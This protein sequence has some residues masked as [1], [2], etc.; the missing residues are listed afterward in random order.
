MILTQCPACAAPLPDLTA[1]QCSR[2]KTRYCGRTCQEYHWKAGHDKV[3][4]KIRKSGGAEQYHANK[5]YTEAVTVAAKACAEDTKGQ[6]CYICTEAVHRHTGEGLVRGCGCHTT[7]GFVHVSCLAEQAKILLAEALENNL[8][9]KVKDAR[10]DRWCTC[11]LCEQRYYGV[12]KCALGWA[13][14]KTY[15]GRPEEDRRRCLAMEVLGTGLSNVHLHADALPVYEAQLSTMR[16]LGADEGSLFSTQGYLAN[17]YKWLGRKE[18]A[19]RLRREVYFGTL[20]LLGEEHRSTII[21]ATDYAHSF[22]TFKHFDEGKSLLRKV[23]P[24]ARRV[25]GEA[26]ED[27]LRLSWTYAAM[28]FVW[29][30]ATLDDLRE[31]ANRLEELERT[32]LRVLGGAHP[33]TKGIESHLRDARAKLRAKELQEASTPSMRA[34]E[35]D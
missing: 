24:V 33:H 4:R 27:W 26:D 25:L 20:K 22:E 7:E 2:C 32:T 30:E 9:D 35:V 31:A 16:R 13:C 28:L 19:L 23:M 12:V 21:A 14:W 5:K 6:T 8:D 17:V 11:S 15:L 34:P 18:E 3:C 1:K 29:P 10:F